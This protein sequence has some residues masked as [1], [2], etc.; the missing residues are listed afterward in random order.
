MVRREHSVIAFANLWSA[1]DRDELSVDLMRYVPNA[2]P[3]LMDYLFAQVM[4]WG[5]HEGYRWFNLGMAP[6][7]GFQIDETAT[8]WSR[9][10]ALVYEHGEA[11]Y[12]F[13]GLRNYKEKF[14]P[15]WRP[16]FLASPGGLS[17]PRRRG[18]HHR[19]RLGRPDRRAA[20]V[21]T[22]GTPRRGACATLAAVLSAGAI[23]ACEAQSTRDAT[24]SSYPIV[25]VA[26]DSGRAVA[27][28]LTG[29][30]G[31]ATGDRAL[32]RTL[33]RGGVAV[34][35]LDSRA[36]LRS[37]HRTP[38]SVAHDA[39][40]ILER[41]A[42]L[43]HRDHLV[44]IGYSRGAD[45]APFIVSRFPSELRSRLALVAF[46]GLAD[47]ANFEFHWQDLVR[48][49]RRASDLPTR[50]ELE[51]IRGVRMLCVYGV[52]EKGSVC[53]SLDSTLARLGRISG[54]HVLDTSSGAAATLVL[55]ALR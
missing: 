31:W 7:S 21:I 40:E 19:A 11:F 42:A 2:L 33:A 39:A 53:P 24:E 25:E 52:D 46:V 5:A 18:E 45:L 34:I 8:G 6:L 48:D 51:R 14:R 43:W 49:P 37:A 15:E 32:A 10:A 50:P 3:G 35:G 38:E 20:E 54:G 4:A 47:H 17:L 30:G 23:T 36:Y 9:L 12:N 26:A 16:R 22:R 44:L 13:R 41:Y 55:R 29:D 28:L 1:G 27:L